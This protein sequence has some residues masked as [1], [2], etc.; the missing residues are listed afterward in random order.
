[1]FEI[2]YHKHIPT[3]TKTEY[4]TKDVFLD[5][6]EHKYLFYC[7]NLLVNGCFSISNPHKYHT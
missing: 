4:E 7:S 2:L 5:R 1:M 6:I 3:I